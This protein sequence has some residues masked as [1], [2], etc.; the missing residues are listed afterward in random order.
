MLARRRGSRLPS[1]KVIQNKSPLQMVI[2]AED[3]DILVTLTAR[4]GMD[5][6]IY[7]LKLGKL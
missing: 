7:F 4:A 1:A 3:V 5:K 6:E 2:V